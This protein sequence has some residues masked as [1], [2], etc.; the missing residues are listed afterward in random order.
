M[1]DAPPSGHQTYRARPERLMI[2]QAVAMYNFAIDKP[3]DRGNADMG[4]GANVHT[5]ANGKSCRPK[6]I[7]KYIRSNHSPTFSR[8]N[9]SHGKPT[10][11]LLLGPDKQFNFV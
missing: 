6:M 1:Y 11:V 5:F 9:P 3:C 10:K 8:Q 4:M 7:K 2:T